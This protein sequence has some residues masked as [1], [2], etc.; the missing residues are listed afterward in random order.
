MRKQP[1]NNTTQAKQI[2]AHPIF[3]EGI[4]VAT[5][6]D[7]GESQV[8][9]R[10]GLCLWLPSKWLRPIMVRATTL[11]QI[12]SKRLLEA[13]RLGV[14][15]HQD[16]EHFT[17]GRAYEINELERSM[18]LLRNGSGGS[19]LVEGAYG[20]GK[21][22]LLE[23]AR[24]MSLK[25]G[26]VTAYCELST[27]ETPLHRPKR[28]YRELIYTL[29]F[30]KDGCE[31]HFRDLLRMASK[32]SM[33]DHVFLSPVLKRIKNVGDIDLMSEV[34]WQWIEGES[35]KN[36]AIDPQAP[37]RVKGGQKIPALYDFSTAGD[38]YSYLITGISYIAFALG[39]GGLVCL[40]D[41]FET[42]SH[43]WDYTHY[44]R[45]LSF[46]EGMILSS[47]NKEEM[48]KIDQRLV[49]NRVRPTPYCY[50]TAHLFL[51]LAMTP[52]HGFR[53]ISSIIESV[54]QRMML[55]KFSKPELEVIFEHLLDVYACAYPDH[56]I[57]SA[58]RDTIYNAAM[59]KG[60]AELREFIK[61]SV[62]AM[63]WLRL[64]A[65]ELR[66]RGVE[67]EN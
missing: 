46:M 52:I 28:V 62:E 53:T 51:V 18:D 5:R 47:L 2:V 4:V 57:E 23:Y 15:P 27:A 19:C 49:H 9:F 54:P 41:E 58:R 11:D 10:S 44:D 14:V 55:R 29:R 17:F 56:K 60:S 24:H 36:Y 64:G 59:K 37:F 40:F 8:R 63:D 34:F 13:F 32:I 50:N 35:T 12:S 16:I 39:F 61:F 30:I 21:T 26:L 66:N 7:Q 20:S 31:Y 25:K 22:H 43:V 38:F 45:S 42:V 48:K 6:W 65:G 33:N 3:G 1:N 67:P